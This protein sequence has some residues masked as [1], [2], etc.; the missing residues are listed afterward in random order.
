[1]Y[2]AI[3]FIVLHTVDGREV[4]V[5]PAQVT[6]LQAAKETTPN[7]LVAEAVRCIVNLTDGKFITVAEK[8]SEVRR[9]L[10]IAR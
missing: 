6:S 10:E 8:C 1:M 3:L 5:S 2:P 9:L 7:S 4:T